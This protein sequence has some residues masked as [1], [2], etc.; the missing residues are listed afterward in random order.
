[1]LLTTDPTLKN[2]LKITDFGIS[3]NIEPGQLLCDRVG[4]PHFMAPEV[5]KGRYTE[6]CDVWSC[7]VMLFIF[8]SGSPPFNGR[9]REEIFAS[10]ERGNFQF[11]TNAWRKVTAEAKDLVRRLMI[12]NPEER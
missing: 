5:I 11:N 6:A 2:V 9:K 3:C 12:Y 4:T 10:I 7:G 1:M 8:L